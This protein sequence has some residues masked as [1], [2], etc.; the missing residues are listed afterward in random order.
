MRAVLAGIEQE[1]LR[2]TAEIRSGMEPHIGAVGSRP[3]R[4]RHVLEISLIGRGTAREKPSALIERLRTVIRIVVLH[5][6]V[7]PG[8]DPRKGRMRCLQVDAGRTR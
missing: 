5:F 1:E 3:L 2:E 6:V 7:V 4:Q 8:H